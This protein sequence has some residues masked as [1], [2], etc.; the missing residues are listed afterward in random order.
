M[1]PVQKRLRYTLFLSPLLIS[2]CFVGSAQATLG[3]TAGSFESNRVVL[4]SVH[5]ATTTQGAYTIQEDV[6]DAATIRQYISSSGV[7]F[8]VTWNGVSHPDLTSLLGSYYD[9][10]SQALQKRT[11]TPGRRHVQIRGNR[12]VVE[13]WGH[14]RNLQGRAYVPGL[15]PSGV[16]L[17]EIR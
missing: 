7:I 11:R 15:L 9:E 14:M 16:N 4:K 5:K 13:K 12:V 17:N 6:S 3:E 1:H 10:Y 2:L 8:A